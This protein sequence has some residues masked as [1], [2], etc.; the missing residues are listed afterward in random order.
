M[1][2]TYTK[3]AAS[4]YSFDTG[5]IQGLVHKTDGR[6]FTDKTQKSTKTRKEAI[7]LAI[8]TVKQQTK[9]KQQTKPVDYVPALD[10]SAHYYKMVTSSKDKKLSFTE[11]GQ[12]MAATYSG[13][14]TCST[15]CPLYS[16]CYAKGG[17]TNFTFE[18]MTP[19]TAKFEKSSEKARGGTFDSMIQAIADTLWDQPLRVS[20]SG[21][22]PSADTENTLDLESV[23]KLAKVSKKNKLK[24]WTYTHKNDVSN[25][26]YVQDLA[27]LNSDHWCLNISTDTLDQAVESFNKGLPT[28]ITIARKDLPGGKLGFKYRDVIFKVCPNQINASK[29]RCN[30]CMLCQNS[31]RDHVVVFIKH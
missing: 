11:R 10:K 23:G 28:V 6:W 1:K 13:K 17:N 5:L 7:E 26:A 20:I 3:I 24:A 27:S 15:G 8:A 2:T 30:N 31:K 21:D 16:D 22:L 9:E 25:L 29:V 12:S 4:F 18:A 19:G 14:N